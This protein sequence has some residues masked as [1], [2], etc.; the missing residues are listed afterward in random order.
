[1][2]SL[3]LGQASFSFM[4]RKMKK[5]C[6]L[7]LTNEDG[8]VLTDILGLSPEEVQLRLLA[9]GIDQERIGRAVFTSMD[10]EMIVRCL[11]SSTHRQDGC[12]QVAAVYPE[13]NRENLVFGEFRE[14]LRWITEAP[15]KLPSIKMFSI[16]VDENSHR[17]YR[18]LYSRT[19][20]R[21]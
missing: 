4:E 10:N 9:E 18:E 16:S 7:I 5:I 11:L 20:L 13:G 3:S 19:L 8:T 21:S 15:E 6:N 17:T 12:F 14:A 1:M 2:N